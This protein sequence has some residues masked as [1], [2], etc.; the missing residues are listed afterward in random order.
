M[1][2]RGRRRR[3]RRRRIRRR[4]RRR[5]RRRNCPCQH[6]GQDSTDGRATR[7]RLDGPGIESWWGKIFR[8][9]PDWHWGPSSLQYNG[10]WVIS[11]V[12]VAREWR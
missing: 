6:V 7:Y 10:Y 11:G 1:R 12:K 4:R 5:R 2:R 3:R 8:T 9:P